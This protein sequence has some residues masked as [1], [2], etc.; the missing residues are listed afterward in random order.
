[1]RYQQ[2][3]TTARVS[4]TDSSRTPKQL[5]IYKPCLASQ[6]PQKHIIQLNQIRNCP[7][8]LKDIQ[9][10]KKIFGDNIASLKG[11][12]TRWKPPI[13][14][15]DFIEI[16]PK[17]LEHNKEITLNIDNMFICGLPQFTGNDETVRA[18]HCLPLSSQT[19]N[20]FYKAINVLMRKYNGTG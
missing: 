11:K 2:W 9:N 6:P 4:P 7:I 10:A 15:E 17:I 13:I 12:S 19:K 5:G 20:E 16:P 14:K 18:R 8:T 1:M 3:R